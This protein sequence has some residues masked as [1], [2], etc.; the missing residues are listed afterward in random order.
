MPLPPRTNDKV[1][2]PEIERLLYQVKVI[3]EEATGLFDGLSQS[4]FNWHPTP[5]SWSLGQCFDHLNITAKKYL[6]NLE[7]AIAA[8]RSGGQLGEGPYVYGFLGR[9]FQRMTLPPVKRR[10]SAPAVFRPAADKKMD[11]VV[12]EWSQVHDRMKKVIESANGIDLQRVKVASPASNLL[13][14]SLGMGFW[15]LTAHEKRHL[16][17]ARN[18]RNAKGFPSA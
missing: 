3:E 9:M 17:Q 15:I 16:W 18:V 8:A 14:I 1:L 4:Q 13:K 7:A 12:N 5:G 2:N 11:A 10:F 6:D